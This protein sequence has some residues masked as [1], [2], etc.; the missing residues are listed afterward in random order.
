MHPT[1]GAPLGQYVFHL[2]FGRG[3]RGEQQI[4]LSRRLSNV[5]FH[6][7][8]SYETQPPGITALTRL[9]TAAGDD[10]QLV[11]KIKA[12]HRL[13]PTLKKVIDKLDH[14][15]KIQALNAKNDGGINRNPSIDS[16]H[17]LVRYHPVLCKK[18]LFLDSSFSIRVFG[19]KDEKSRAFLK[20]LINH[21]EGLFDAHIRVFWGENIVIP[22]DNRPLIYT[23]TIHW[24]SNGIRHSFGI[25]T[26]ADRLV[27][28]K[29]EYET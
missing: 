21:T 29:E 26:L 5:S 24:D 3:N 7:D 27:R 23:A 8:V 28:N 10:T 13:S 17:P 12:Y 16:I 14:T 2:T 11:D 4:L 18:A 20:L 19:L 6:S 9:Q 25:T 1:L 22:W 15:S